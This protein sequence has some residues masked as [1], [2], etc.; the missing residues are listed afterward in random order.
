[1]ENMDN[2]TF[3]DLL[4]FN[5]ARKDAMAKKEHMPCWMVTSDEAKDGMRRVAIQRL[6]ETYG[7]PLTEQGAHRLL[8]G[9]EEKFQYMMDNWKEVEMKMRDERKRGVPQAFFV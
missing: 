6:S 1:M 5:E 4:A 7:M 2:A 9:S 3:L 8:E